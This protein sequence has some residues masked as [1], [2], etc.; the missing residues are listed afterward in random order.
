MFYDG[1][2]KG[3]NVLF[4]VTTDSGVKKIWCR[5]KKAAQEQASACKV[6][7]FSCVQIRKCH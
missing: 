6:L 1:F 4:K 2:I 3:Y 7:G 5:D